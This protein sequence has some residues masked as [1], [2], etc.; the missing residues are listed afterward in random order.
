MCI[1]NIHVHVKSI[2]RLQSHK[3]KI[4][5]FYHNELLY[6]VGIH[7]HTCTHTGTCTCTCITLI[8]YMYMYTVIMIVLTK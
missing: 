3:L 7:V 4:P 1:K 8:L 6:N 2:M 5:Q